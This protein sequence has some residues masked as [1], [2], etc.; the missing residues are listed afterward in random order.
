[1]RAIGARTIKDRGRARSSMSGHTQIIEA[2]ES[3]NASRAEQLVR[4]HV[5]RL[6]DHVEANL[7]YLE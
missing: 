7:D 6:S 2:I 5:L 3:R 1:M 4:D